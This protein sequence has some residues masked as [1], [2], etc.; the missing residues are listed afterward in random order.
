MNFTVLILTRFTVFFTLKDVEKHFL[1]GVS[2]H[3][4]SK[5]TSCKAFKKAKWPMGQ[6]KR[7]KGQAKHVST[8]LF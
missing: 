4:A 2:N 3:N 8:Y 6:N 1:L 5:L 7:T